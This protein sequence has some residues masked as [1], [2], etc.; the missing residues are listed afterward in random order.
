MPARAY[1]SSKVTPEGGAPGHQ[2]NQPRPPAYRDDVSE[3]QRQ[4]R[5]PGEVQR[6]AEVLGF[7]SKLRA[8]GIQQQA[9]ADHEASHPGDE[10][11]DDDE[12]TVDAEEHFAAFRGRHA[13]AN[14]APYLP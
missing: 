2:R 4:Q 11:E 6:G 13:Q 1:V 9:V 14:P 5:R 12:R 7:G 8:Q 3:T 10:Q